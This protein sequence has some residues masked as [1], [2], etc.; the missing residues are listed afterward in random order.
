M[1]CP[2]DVNADDCFTVVQLETIEDIYAGAY[3]SRG[4]SSLKGKALGSEFGWASQLIPYK[5]NF[6]AELAI[7]GD[8]I[9]YL[10]YETDPGVPMPDLTDPSRIRP[11]T[12]RNGPGGNL[13]LMISLP[14]GVT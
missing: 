8:H 11:P 5:G 13:M 7:S 1:M 9:N 3:D 12:P 10:F 14:V 2:G 6:P 4:T